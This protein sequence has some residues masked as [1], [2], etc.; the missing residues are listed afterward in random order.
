MIGVNG[1]QP[2]GTLILHADDD[3]GGD[4]GDDQRKYYSMYYSVATTKCAGHN[5]RANRQQK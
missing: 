1:L 2:I 5:G 3:G 4:D